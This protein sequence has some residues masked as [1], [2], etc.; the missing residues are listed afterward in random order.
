MAIME[1]HLEDPLRNT[2][3]SGSN[4]WYDYHQNVG[5]L[6]NPGHHSNIPAHYPEDSGST[7]G[8]AYF[9]QSNPQLNGSYFSQIYSDY[10]HQTQGHQHGF[11]HPSMWSFGT[12]GPPQPNPHHSSSSSTTSSSSPSPSSYPYPATPSPRLEDVKS[13]DFS[14]HLTAGYDMHSVFKTTKKVA[15]SSIEGRECVNCGATSTPLWRRDG[16]GHYLCNACGLYYK[17]NG[18][19]RPLVKP[20]RKIVRKDTFT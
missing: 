12:M 7:T 11:Y 17:M 6:G 8:N 14:H 13:E 19:N 18:M 9:K 5:S 10:G 16:N 2:S 20:K 4:S 15:P 1:S 3:V